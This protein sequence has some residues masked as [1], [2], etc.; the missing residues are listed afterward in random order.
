MLWTEPEKEARVK[1]DQHSSEREAA[2]ERELGREENGREEQRM[3]AAEDRVGLQDEQAE[4]DSHVEETRDGQA[5]TQDGQAR[6][7]AHAETQDDD[8][9]DDAGEQSALT[10]AGAP[11]RDEVT[12]SPQEMELHKENDANA[13]ERQKQEEG[14]G[15]ERER[16]RQAKI[17]PFPRRN[18]VLEARND[19]VVLR[20][21][22]VERADEPEDPFSFDEEDEREEQE[23][24]ERKA[25]NR[26]RLKKG[27]ALFISIALVANVLA[28]WPMLYNVQAI[29]FLAISRELSAN[30]DIAAYKRAVAV[31][32]TP[33][34]KGTGFLFAP[35]GYVLTNHHVVEGDRAVFVRFDEGGS[36]EA[37]VVASEAAL[38]MAVL[39]IKAPDAAVEER[40]TLTLL[41][42]AAWRSGETVRIIGNPLFFTG[43]ANQGQIV[44]ELRVEGL[45]HPAMAI[46]APIYKGNSGSPVINERGE[47]IAVVFATSEISEAGERKP[48][49]LAVPIS[50]MLV[51][52]DAIEG[53]GGIED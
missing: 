47:V 5:G 51:Q 39:R 50:A 6:T 20:E 35:G 8:D 24:F 17:I 14:E 22:H 29:R 43:I 45:A 52:I 18:M 4:P 16:P 42:E 25:R 28:F 37:E 46:E 41:R 3:G 12:H 34:G 11:S 44:G 27:L 26:A 15:E 19:D 13:E 48:V 36:Y 23:F 49:G 2:G 1:R 10:K 30:A 9:D 31:V 53:I 7:G 32:S 33:S 21:S 38:D 40:Q